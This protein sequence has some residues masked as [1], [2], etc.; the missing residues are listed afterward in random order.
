MTQERSR[1]SGNVGN[2]EPFV[3]EQ[4]NRAVVE[5][6]L[7]DAKLDPAAEAEL[8]SE[9]YVLEMPQSG[10]RIRGRENMRAFQENYPAPPTVTVREIRGAGNIFVAE[11]TNDYGGDVFHA[12]LILEL[13]EGEIVRDTRYY[14]EPFHPPSWRT[15]WVEPME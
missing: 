3:G 8:R 15:R 1:R 14:A 12:V 13:R 11:L 10:E 5:R 9:D 7:T 2:E 4:E 6:F